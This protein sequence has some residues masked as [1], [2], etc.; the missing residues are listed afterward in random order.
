MEDGL[1]YEKAMQVLSEVEKQLGAAQRR[2]GLKTMLKGLGFFVLAVLA[3]GLSYAY[4]ME[5]GTYLVT[6]GLFIVSLYMLVSGFW[7]VLWSKI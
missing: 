6:S 7:K 3:T 5:N 1:S 4:P 2:L